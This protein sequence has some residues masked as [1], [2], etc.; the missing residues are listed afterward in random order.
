MDGLK[1]I[2]I[3]LHCSHELLSKSNDLFLHLHLVHNGH[4]L[5]QLLRKALQ[6]STPHEIVLAPSHEVL[7]AVTFD[8]FAC[9][10][11]YFSYA[12]LLDLASSAKGVPTQK[13]DKTGAPVSDYSDIP[14]SQIRKVTVNFDLIVPLTVLLSASIFYFLCLMI[15][16]CRSRLHD[17]CFPNRLFLI[18]I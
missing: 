5:L 3:V 1:C 14:I 18:T 15:R 13:K 11:A 7:H 12:S 9:I 6:S 10:A 2:L 4:I 17:C 16:S 8:S